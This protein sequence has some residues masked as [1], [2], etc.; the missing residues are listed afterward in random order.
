M[1]TPGTFASIDWNCRAV[2]FEPVKV[3]MLEVAKKRILDTFHR[4]APLYDLSVKME[5]PNRSDSPN[6]L[7]WSGT[8]EWLSQKNISKSA[9]F[10]YILW[11]TAQ[12]AEEIYAYV[13]R[14]YP[15]ANLKFVY[16]Y[17]SDVVFHGRQSLRPCQAVCEEHKDILT[18]VTSH[19]A[20]EMAKEIFESIQKPKDSYYIC[21][22]EFL[23]ESDL[24]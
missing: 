21:K 4:Y 24:H 12:N 20:R 5:N 18:I 11:G 7:Y 2:N 17:Y 13:S 1:Y 3:Q 8:I 22:M 19:S 15:N 9:A 6:L 14:E 23:K 16:N 10:D